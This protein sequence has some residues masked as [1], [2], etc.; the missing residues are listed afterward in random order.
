MVIPIGGFG[1]PMSGPPPP[2]LAGRFKVIK[3][4]ILLMIGS[5]IAKLFGGI[6][7]N[8]AFS[9]A[10]NSLNLIL[11]TVI[12]IWLLRDDPKIGQI[13]AFLVRTCCQMCAEQCQGGMTCLM[14]FIISNLITVVLDLFSGII[15]QLGHY[16]NIISSGMMDGVRQLGLIIFT[17]AA[18]VALVAQGVGVFQ[19]FM[20]YREARDLGTSSRPGEWAPQSY[21]AA[22]EMNQQ[23][24]APSRAAPKFQAFQGAG[25]RLGGT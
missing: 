16:F 18:F 3:L 25:N 24:E 12:G 9:Q 4:C 21:P 13:Y 10:V 20:A 1:T 5:V 23:T 11:N 6:L 14:P 8:V 7:L 15:Q 2:E 17:L 22:R 19:G